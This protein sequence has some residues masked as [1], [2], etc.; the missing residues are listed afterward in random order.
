MKFFL[1][2]IVAF[3]S[4]N[5]FAKTGYVDIMEAFEKTKQGR[6]VKAQLEK[7]AETAK[8]KF[9]SMELKIQ[10]EEEA[11]KKEAPILTEQA[12]AEKIQQLQQKILNFQ[13]DVK[14]KDMELQN[15]QNKLMKPIIE[16]LKKVSGEV[17]KAESYLVVENINNDILW[18]SPKLNLTQKVY[19]KYNKKYK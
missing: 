8:N 13:K 9:K 1:L 14:N 7:T 18:V 16:K 5:S 3:Y 10:K 6:R 19:K 11:L 17:A 2:I 12:R 15:L 4:F